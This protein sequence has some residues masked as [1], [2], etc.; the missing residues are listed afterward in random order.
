MKSTF[1]APVSGAGGAGN[2]CASDYP[3]GGLLVYKS[4]FIVLTRVSSMVER[5]VSKT[6]TQ[7]DLWAARWW[8]SQL[9]P[10]VALPASP[11]INV[12]V[13]LNL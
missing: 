12:V 3:S 7:V 1:L 9:E 11:D 5:S 4:V 2:S 10:A 8:V 6:Q 13:I